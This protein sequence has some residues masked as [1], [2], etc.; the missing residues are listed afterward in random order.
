MTRDAMTDDFLN[1]L[2]GGDAQ[3]VRVEAL[4]E[5]GQRRFRFLA[6]IEGETFVSWMEKQQMQALGLAIEQMLEQFPDT[7]PDLGDPDPPIEFD[8][9]TRHQFRVGRMEL[10]LDADTDRVVLSAYDIQEGEEEEGDPTLAVRIS[11]A[12]ART[13]SVDAQA[14]VASGRPLCPMCG[15]PIDTRPHVCPQQNGH[16]P[17]TLDD[18]TEEPQA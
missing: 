10:A 14:L 17:L 5:P 3:R 12:Q 4:G 18:E 9:A 15:S 13:V 6:L 16:L 7:G 8:E 2:A 1:P 11:K